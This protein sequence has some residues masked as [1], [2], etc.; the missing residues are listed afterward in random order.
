MYQAMQQNNDYD[1]YRRKHTKYKEKYLALK[2]Q[3][4]VL[5]DQS[6][7]DYLY[8]ILQS[9]HEPVHEAL[10]E[11]IHEPMHEAPHGQTHELLHEPTYE[12]THGQI[13]EPMHNL[14]HVDEWIRFQDWKIAG[15]NVID[16]MELFYK[17][18]IKL[19]ELTWGLER[20]A[21]LCIKK[22]DNEPCVWKLN[23]EDCT[24]TPTNEPLKKHA[25]I[26]ADIITK[27]NET[28]TKVVMK[29]SAYETTAFI[30][31]I[32]DMNKAQFRD[33]DVIARSYIRYLDEITDNP[34]KALIND[35]SYRCYHSLF[36]N[37]YDDLINIMI[38]IDEHFTKITQTEH[39]DNFIHSAD[40]IKKLHALMN[41]IKEVTRKKLSE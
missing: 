38:N 17:Y 24:D 27:F 21:C 9:I 41:V 26:I 20:C 33:L 14:S 29:G 2:K 40:N 39:I 4:A 7:A 8:N 31:D 28:Y 6:Q 1:K 37:N 16:I 35:A 23:Y 12:L 18:G 30:K 3:I 22:H 10:H 36:I 5:C 34:S 13:H 32:I 11:S 19:S 25:A 15:T